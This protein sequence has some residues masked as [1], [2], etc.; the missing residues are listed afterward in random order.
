MGKVGLIALNVA[1]VLTVLAGCTSKTSPESSEP[2]GS[3]NPQKSPEAAA[4]LNKG[5]EKN[6]FTALLETNASW[7]Y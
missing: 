6:T 5:I 2:S 4:T 3:G 1:L 7:P